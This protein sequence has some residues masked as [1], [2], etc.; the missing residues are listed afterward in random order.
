[1]PWGR[2]ACDPYPILRVNEWL[3]QASELVIPH[4]WGIARL[5]I[6]L[7]GPPWPPREPG[8]I[9]SEQPG[10]GRQSLVYSHWSLS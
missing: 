5:R 10:Y 4:P 9:A 1:M 2:A 3:L 8:D 7:G 6:F